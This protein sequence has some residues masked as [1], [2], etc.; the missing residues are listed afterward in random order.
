[1]SDGQGASDA[2]WKKSVSLILTCLV[3]WFTVSYG[4]GILF[5][6]ALDSIQIA[7]FRLGFWFAQQGSIYVFIALIFFYAYRMNQIDS[8]HGVRED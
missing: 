5:A 7:G 2:Y 8:E 1:M 3:I 6:E 4:C